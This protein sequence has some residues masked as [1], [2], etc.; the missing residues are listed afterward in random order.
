MSAAQQ[1]V[2]R[3]V[4]AA[5]QAVKG[6]MDALVGVHSVAQHTQV[7]EKL[8]KLQPHLTEILQEVLRMKL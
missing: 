6:A 7:Y 8:Q 4:T 1:E 3:F 2:A 5:Q